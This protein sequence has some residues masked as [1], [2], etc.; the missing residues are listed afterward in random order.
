MMKPGIFLSLACCAVLSLVACGDDDEVDATTTTTTTSS[1]S[2]SGGASS[3]SSSG[4]GG[5]AQ[6]GGGQG[7]MGQGGG[8][9][10]VNGCTRASAADYKGMATVDIGSESTWDFGHQA[11]IVVDVGTTVEWSGNLNLH[12][13]SGGPSGTA[14]A[15]SPISMA[16][17]QGNTLSVTFSSAGDFPY[18]CAVHT[19]MMGVVYVE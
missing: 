12:P 1:S 8:G 2:G 17:P 11:C 3:S 14:D 9:Q 13:V 5:Q 16:S 15:G 10:T 18:F 4:S 6:G 7:G 19:T